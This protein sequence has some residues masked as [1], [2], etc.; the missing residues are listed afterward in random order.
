MNYLELCKKVAQISG[1]IAGLPNFDDVRDAT[2]R[3]AKLT[4]CVSDAWM[5]IQ[6]ERTDW[7]WQRKH[8]TS[9]LI[10]GQA[11]YTSTELGLGSVNAWTKDR[12]GFHP[13]SLYDTA[14]GKADEGVISYIDY[15]VWREMYGRGVHDANRPN[16]WSVDPSTRNLLVGA[17]PD[18]AYT[19][20]GEYR[21]GAFEL[22]D[23]DDIPDMPVEYHRVIV[24]EAIRLLSM[25]DEAYQ[26]MAAMETEYRR[27]RN[28]LINNQT[29]DV[30]MSGGPFA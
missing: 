14:V 25:G 17:T 4:G 27:L 19:L 11:V 28:G 18:K 2:G 1:T 8:F 3:L 12:Y 9:P 20:A 5:N 13:F 16:Q 30:S 7:L 21:A 15:D 6:N 29:P 24:F 10:I 22:V 26:P 23:N